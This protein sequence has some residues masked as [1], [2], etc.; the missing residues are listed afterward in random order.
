MA[1]SSGRWWQG[2]TAGS[3]KATTNHQHQHH[4]HHHNPYPA[5]ERSQHQPRETGSTARWAAA[6]PSGSLE[7]PVR[8]R[9]STNAGAAVD[10]MAGGRAIPRGEGRGSSRGGGG[11]RG[12]GWERH[13]AGMAVGAQYPPAPHHYHGYRGQSHPQ[14]GQH[15]WDTKPAAL[16]E[17]EDRRGLFFVFD[18]VCFLL[19]FLLL[20]FLS[21]TPPSRSIAC[22][23]KLLLPPCARSN[24]LCS[25]C[26]LSFSENTIESDG[27]VQ[28][29]S[30]VAFFVENAEVL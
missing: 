18:F 19:C 30:F 23:P 16:Q 15:V 17:V 1:A 28:D 13:A 29:H 9:R 12:T 7:S 11:G 20:F 26:S 6:G 21:R 14:Q 27:F 5:V 2:E 25:A 10:S 24:S 4:P 3:S 8:I 22:L